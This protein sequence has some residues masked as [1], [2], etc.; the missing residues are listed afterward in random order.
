MTFS[1]LPLVLL[2]LASW[3]ASGEVVATAA[4]PDG[5][6][7]VELT[8]DAEGR[9]GY[10]L[11][12]L[13]RPVIADSRLGILLANAHKLERNFRLEGTERRSADSTWE[14]P[15]GE[16]RFVRDRYQ[17]LRARLV[18]EPPRGRR[19]D[20][21]FRVHDDGIGFRYEFPAQ[22]SLTRVE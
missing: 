15:W 16:R 9:P 4:S 8:L 11:S 13:G 18:E 14:Q 17:E 10:A 1:R 2:L 12:R 22:A 21:V 5:S 19:L 6:L 7:V 3:P 20:V